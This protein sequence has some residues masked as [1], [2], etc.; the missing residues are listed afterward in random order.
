MFNSKDNT[1]NTQ[2]STEI[3]LINSWSL[4]TQEEKYVSNVKIINRVW[5]KLDRIIVKKWKKVSW[6]MLSLRNKLLKQLEIYV[7]IPKEDKPAKVKN[8]KK[9]IIKRN[10]I[11]VYK[12]F[13]KELKK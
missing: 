8:I 12:K 3:S 2:N 10:V 11:R 1:E 7:L 13:L 5:K 4:I 9:R 6:E